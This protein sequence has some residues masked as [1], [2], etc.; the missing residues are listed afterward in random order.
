MLTDFRV[1]FRTLGKSPAFTLT[2]IAA[3]ALG[4]GANTAIFSLVNQ[5]LLNPPGVSDPA[6]IVTLRAKYDKLNLAS[7]PMSTP[8]F[9]DVRKSTPIFEYVAGMDGGNFNYTG[10]DVPERLQGAAVTVDWFSVFGTAP[11]LGRSFRP[12]EDQPNNNRVI[13]L[14]YPTWIRLF[15]G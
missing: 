9:A 6:R 3:L 15:G 7:I 11:M 5:V 4:V 10:G 13:V 2:A 1:A 8:D 12:E 14:S